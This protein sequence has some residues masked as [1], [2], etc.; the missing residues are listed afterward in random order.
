MSQTTVVSSENLIVF[1]WLTFTSH[2]DSPESL[3]Q[4][5]GLKDVSWQM[6]ERGYNGYRG[7]LFFE[8]ISILFDGQESMGVCVNMSGMGCRAFET[9]SMI[10]WQE[11]MEILFYGSGDYNVTRLDMAFDDHTGILDIDT[12]WN[13]TLDRHYVSKAKTSEVIISD[14]Q[15]TDIR[16]KTVKIGSD[17]SNM[18]IRIYDK[19][20]ERVL[21]GVH[22]IRV[23]MQMRDEIATGFIAGLMNNPVGIHFRGVLH[24]YLRFVVP[25]SDSNKS[26]WPLA[27]Y[28][29]DLLEGVQ[30]IRCWTDPGEEYNEFNLSN[31]V[32]NQAGNA[33]DCY[34]QI[35]SIDDLIRELGN[36]SIKPSPKYQR[37]LAKYRNLKRGVSDAGTVLSALEEM[38]HRSEADGEAALQDPV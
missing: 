13:D 14:N 12:I 10:T 33:I 21:A 37:L 31:F 36:R 9:Y 30:Q 3:M 25:Q 22:W 20:A 27:K 28:W 18:L 26:R 1:D 23:E 32:I 35:F 6:M 16:G 7:R 17:R 19:A 11:L 2:C 5:L 24:N 4:L 29:S 15:L 8:N 38:A 34:L